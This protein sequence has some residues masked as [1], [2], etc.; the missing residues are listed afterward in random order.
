MLKT[1][2]FTKDIHSAVLYYLFFLLLFIPAISHAQAQGII[3]GK[4]SSEDG[5]PIHGA[6]VTLIGAQQS[7]ESDQTGH[8]LFQALKPS[9]YE[10]KVSYMGRE[11]IKKID[12]SMDQRLSLHFVLPQD[13]KS[14]ETVLVSVNRKSIPS[15]TLRLSENLLVT[16]QNI[17]IIDNK[18]L[19]DQMILSTAE[20][21]TRN[22][23]GARTIYH[24]EEGS[25]GISTRGYSASNL[26]NGMDVSGSFGPLREDMSFV[27]RIEFVKGPAGFMMGNTQPGGFYNIVTKKPKGDGINSA[28]LSL[29]SFGLYRGEVD[30]DGSLSKNKKLLGRF[31][32]M[33]TKKGSHMQNVSN[34]QYVINPSIKY[35]FSDKTD[36]TAEYILSHNSF[37]G[38]F[39]KY[40]YGI[41]GFKELP[42]E[43]NFS[44]PI[45]DPTVVKEHNVFGAINHYF[46]EDW[47][48]TAQFGYIRSEMEGESLY[49]KYNTLD[50]KGDVRRGL[51]VNDAL[52]TSTVGQ[53]FTKGKFNIGSVRNNILMG[54]DMGTKLYVADWTSLA[55]DI[56]APFNIYKPVYGKLKKT[57]IPTYDRSQ[58]LRERGAATLS[59]YSYYSGHLQDE[60]HFLEGKLR[61]GAGIR[62]TRTTRISTAADGARVKNEAFTPRFSITGLITPTFTSYALYD[63][64]FQEQSGSLVNGEAADPSRGKN[65]ELGFKKTFFKEQLLI[66]LTGYHLKRT[67][68]TTPVGPNNPGFVEQSGEA[69]S[70]GIELDI[71]G[72]ISP[73][74]QVMFNYAYTDAKISKDN[75]PERVGMML[76]GTAKHISNAWLYYTLRGGAL[77]GLGF[78]AGYEW[79]AKR[80]AWP[81]VAEKYLPN[82]LFSVDLG[83]SYKKD[84]YHIAL[85]VNNVLN[86]YNY[87]GFYPKAWGYTHYGWRAAPPTSFRLTLGYTF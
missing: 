35:I 19:S 45:I 74:L 2:Y 80:A 20:G 27:E 73:S 16:P 34:E 62:Y 69:T 58:S 44:D 59:E 39:A 6:T 25:T 83:T 76:Y 71:N 15:S 24:Q 51:S 47:M 36:F 4:I 23:S 78:S 81:V 8:Y 41:K 70:K 84:N 49:A 42:R 29:G 26:R 86:K 67:N 60:A 57:D 7:T 10:V 28:R 5:K 46:S 18:Q 63:Q 17:V 77:E 22:I 33:G 75:S 31:N 54:L 64:S 61:L 68:I 65:I 37:T 82:D 9:S 30:L 85:L 32:I 56:G 87:T 13:S 66:G 43:F 55:P 3:Q 48:L 53:V 72:R 50:D 12:L 79:Q 11:Q 40:A 21:F 52:N 1:N 38:G 14:L